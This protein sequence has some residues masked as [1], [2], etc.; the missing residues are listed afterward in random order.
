LNKDRKIYASDIRAE[1]DAFRET[2]WIV[3][4]TKISWRLSKRKINYIRL[5]E[6]Y[7]VKPNVLENKSSN[8]CT[9]SVYWLDAVF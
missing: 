7:P 4:V 9:G 6:F 3:L 5:G 2:F 1:Y 8:G